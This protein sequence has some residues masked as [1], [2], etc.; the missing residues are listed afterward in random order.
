MPL[1]TYFYQAI[2]GAPHV[3]GPNDYAELCMW[4]NGP[5]ASAGIVGLRIVRKVGI[6]EQETYLQFHPASMKGVADRSFTGLMS[7]QE[8]E[9]MNTFNNACLVEGLRRRP[10]LIDNIDGWNMAAD[11]FK[12]EGD[13]A[14]LWWA[15]KLPKS[16]Q[17]QLIKEGKPTRRLPMHSL[18]LVAMEQMIVR[19]KAE[20]PKFAPVAGTLLGQAN[21]ENCASVI[22]R[23]L[24][25]GGADR[26][27][28]PANDELTLEAAFVGALM[29]AA[30]DFGFVELGLL[31]LASALAARFIGGMDEGW[32]AADAIGN[33][34]HKEHKPYAT[35]VSW[36]LHVADMVVSG[37][38][39][40]LSWGSPTQKFL[41]LPEMLVDQVRRIQAV[42][43]H[44]EQKEVR[45]NYSNLI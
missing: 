31:T 34:M 40:A 23:V 19:I 39:G 41:V 44:A 5:G 1:S 45:K 20:N 35:P 43:R 37:V 30:A 28:P 12:L 18:D 27:A 3:N 25:A 9:F 15:Q 6:T 4:E 13:S 14:K 7:G 36:G 33:L 29:G 32:R 16:T 21:T 38:V 10:E 17:E 8:G 24:H 42:E 2:H 11:K 26:I 22:A